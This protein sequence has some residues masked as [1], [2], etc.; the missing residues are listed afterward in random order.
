ML[1]IKYE[2]YCKVTQRVSVVEQGLSN[3]PKHL[4]LPRCSCMGFVL[5]NL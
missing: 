5:L 2:Q 4:C 3:L 1:S